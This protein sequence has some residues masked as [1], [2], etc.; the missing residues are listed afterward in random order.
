MNWRQPASQLRTVMGILHGSRAFGG[1]L[2]AS[3]SLTNRCNIRCIHCYYYSPLVENA[4][5]LN[6]RN[7]RMMKD[8]LPDAK[9]IKQLQ[10]L[11]ADST[12]INQLIDELAGSG[13]QDFLFTGNG[14]PFLHKNILEFVDRT[15][16]A[17]CKCSV[18]TNGI[19]PG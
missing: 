11:D 14:E 6:V 8:E 7:A 17:G 13:T 2:Q 19:C 10:T 4:N 9:Y 5:L 12:R 3:L 1:P 18:N 16:R 15:K